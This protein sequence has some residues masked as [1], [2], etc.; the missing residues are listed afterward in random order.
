MNKTNSRAYFPPYFA[1][2]K[3]KMNKELIKKLEEAAAS[4][5][6]ASDEYGEY[7]L[8]V[9][10]HGCCVV[11]VSC[12][13][14]AWSCQ[15]YSENPITQLIIQQ[16]RYKFLPDALVMVQLFT[17]REINRLQKS[18]VLYEIPAEMIGYEDPEEKEAQ[19]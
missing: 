14:G 17:S 18:V 1:K 16:I 19:K 2:R 6:V 9:F 7:R 11:T 10:L 15:I 12:E 5:P 13:D 8:G 3:A 4:D